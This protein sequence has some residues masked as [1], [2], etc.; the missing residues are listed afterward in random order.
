[1]LNF[2]PIVDIFLAVITKNKKIN[3]KLKGHER[4]LWL[5]KRLHCM[6]DSFNETITI[7]LENN[8]NKNLKDVPEIKC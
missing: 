3:K 4:P 8:E 5:S 2:R 7:V 6:T 1:M